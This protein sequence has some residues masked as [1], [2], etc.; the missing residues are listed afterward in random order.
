MPGTFHAFIGFGRDIMAGVE[1]QDPDAVRFRWLLG[2]ISA[3]FEKTHGMVIGRL[4]VIVAAEDRP[5]ARAIVI[6]LRGAA[7]SD[8]FHAEGLCDAFVGFARALDGLAAQVEPTASG[9]DLTP[10]RDL[11]SQLMCREEQVAALYGETI[12]ELSDLFSMDDETP[13][14]DL[15]GHAQTASRELTRQLVEFRRLAAE[16]RG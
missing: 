12:H 3:L 5:T 8:S 11:V 7:L 4:D 9:T 15:K 2:Q 1:R 14:P 10:A 6:E 13:L 16:F